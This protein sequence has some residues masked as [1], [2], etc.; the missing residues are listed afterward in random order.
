MS[1]RKGALEV[2]TACRTHG[3]W[4]DAALGSRLKDLSPADAALCSR[5]V[6]GVIQNE[7]LLDFYLSNFC[8]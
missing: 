6:Y 5:I 8:T 7:S 4:A 3:A 1:A 2:L